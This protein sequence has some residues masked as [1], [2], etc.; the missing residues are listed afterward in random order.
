MIEPSKPITFLAPED[1]L[2]AVVAILSHQ[3]GRNHYIYEREETWYIG[4]DSYASLIVSSDGEQLI[5]YFQG[6]GE[7]VIPVHE[8]LPVLARDFISEYSSHGNIFGH[9]GFNYSAHVFGRGYVPGRWPLLSLMVPCAQVAVSRDGITVSGCVEE[10]VRSLCKF[11]KVYLS[12]SHEVQT[13]TPTCHSQ[14]VIDLRV[15]ESEYKA[16]VSTAI[17]EIRNGHYAKVVPSRIVNL[18]G[19]VDM[20]ATLQQGRRSNTPARTFSFSHMG[21]QATGFSPELIISITG[22][23]VCTEAVA[24]TRLR[25]NTTGF[26][27]APSALL[28]DPKEVMEHVSAIRGSMKRLARVCCSRTIVVSDFLSVVDRGNVQHL[29]SHVSGRLSPDKDGWDALP[30]LAVAVPGDAGQ[31]VFQEED[32]Q[33][34]EPVPRELYCGAV[35]MIDPSADF[36]EATL[37]LRSVFQDGKRQWLQAGAGISAISDPDREFV[38]T[39]EKLASI[40]PYVVPE[41]SLCR[42]VRERERHEK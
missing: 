42:E 18:P 29:C 26:N 1:P 6:E 40:A 39:C 23:D 31:G 13:T 38:E 24:G 4:L 5:R 12:Y 2:D 10:E 14:M 21:I 9:V 17:S 20:L 36:F 25:D 35:V 19:R 32:M 28:S 37:A 34:F 11:L 30:G 7:K 3:K 27:G 15:N 22:R 16:R 33:E 41:L 8:P